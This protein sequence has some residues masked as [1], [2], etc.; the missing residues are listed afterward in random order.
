MKRTFLL[1]MLLFVIASTFVD[2]AWQ[3]IQGPLMTPWAKE[4]T[5]DNAWLEYPRPQMVRSRWQNLNGLWEYAIVSKDAAQ[6]ADWDGEI[7]VPF[8]VESALSGVKK[9]MGKDNRLWYRR[10]VSI[11]ADWKNSR[12]FLH[13]GAVDWQSTV[14]VNQTK[15]GTHQGG[16]DAFSFD[17]TNALNGQQQ[18]QVVVAVWD[19]TNDG[20]QP[21]GKQVNQPLKASGTPL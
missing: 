5:P 21:R 3:P 10:T 7:L 4:I 17:I 11:P 12:I 19:P 18:A 16:Y 20:C 6:Q 13:F 8:P 1:G 2:A 15:V 9:N 14:W